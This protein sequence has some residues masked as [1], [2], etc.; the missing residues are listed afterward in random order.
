MKVED[1][2]AILTGNATVVSF[3]EY[4]MIDEITEVATI[5]NGGMSYCDYQNL[6]KALEEVKEMG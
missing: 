6:H 4:A 5:F 2:K 3:L 1:Y